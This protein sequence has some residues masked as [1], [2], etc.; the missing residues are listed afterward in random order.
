MLVAVAAISL[1]GGCD[2]TD[3]SGTARFSVVL[4]DA[5]GDVDQAVVRIERVELVGGSGGPLV[6]SSEPWTG[7]LTQLTNE[8]AMLVDE[9]VIP[10]GTYSQLRLIIPE[11]CIGVETDG[12]PNEV[13]E[14][15]GASSEVSCDGTLTG[16]LQMPS[17]AQTGIKVVFQGA[18]EVTGDTKIVMI[19][20]NVEESFGK[21]A[22]GSGQWVMHPVIH[23]ADLTFAGTLNVTAK[24]ADGLVDLG[25][26]IEDFSVS[27]D[28]SPS[29]PLPLDEDGK[30][31]FLYVVPGFRS[32]DVVPPAGF[33]IVADPT[34][35]HEVTIGEQ[36][37]T[38]VLITITEI[39]TES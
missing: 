38:E 11:A 21:L 30:A 34:V 19:D 6:L 5:A 29:P 15:E 22:G 20:F 17:L 9:V 13:H 33:T 12:G 35:P 10:Q 18:I 7:D 4:T 37:V 32:L 36:E 23:G 28:G 27:L 2:S 26:A 16:P 1:I 3:P 8:F 31:S 25:N 14:S 39:A 24:F